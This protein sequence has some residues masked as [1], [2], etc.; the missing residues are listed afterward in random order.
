MIDTYKDKGARKRLIGELR[1][2]GIVDEKVLAAMLKIPRHFF[3]QPEF[4]SHAYL[5]KAFKIDA[6]QTISQPYTVA[7]QTQLLQI[8]KDDK[9][10]EVGTGSAYQS[11]I[12]LE[13]GVHLYTIERQEALF[14]KAH[15]RIA[16]F[17]YTATCIFGDGSKGYAQGAP[18][19]KI[20]V[21]AGAPVLPQALIDQLKIG[22]ILIIPIGDSNTQKMHSIIKTSATGFEEIT[23][24]NFR[25]V[26]LIGEQA[27]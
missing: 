16:D 26:P 9:V 12:L 18:Y 10:L 2:K 25:F 21:T 23:L 7:Y 24:E 11:I 3:I 6:G 14:N 17:G 4:K 1:A 15:K 8:E 20:I 13:L 19:D 5:D 27:W 22:G